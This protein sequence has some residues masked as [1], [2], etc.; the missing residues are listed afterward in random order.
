[1]AE[2]KTREFTTVPCAKL[3]QLC[4]THQVHAK[5]ARMLG[6]SGSSVNKYIAEGKC[7]QSIELACEALLAREQEQEE[8]KILVVRTGGD[9]AIAI[10]EL[11]KALAVEYTEL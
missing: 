3:I 6:V 4:A 8:N 2:R 10:R 5:V 9:R 7:P 11:C 1:M